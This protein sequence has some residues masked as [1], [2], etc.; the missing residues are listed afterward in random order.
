MNPLR[1]IAQWYISRSLDLD[2]PVPR[3]VARRM[4]S[5]PQ[6]RAFYQASLQ[7]TRQ[8]Q[9]K[10]TVDV[11]ERPF[12]VTNHGTSP[13]PVWTWA[14]LGTMAAAVTILVVFLSRPQNSRPTQ[15]QTAGQA[16]RNGSHTPSREEALLLV[17]FSEACM[18]QSLR[19]FHSLSQ[20]STRPTWSM[21]DS[22]PLKHQSSEL[23]TSVGKILARVEQQARTSPRKWMATGRDSVDYFAEEIPKSLTTWLG[24]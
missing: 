12:V 4:E 8:L 20:H 2:I 14:A 18:E 16:E 13:R 17:H 10:S 3:W 24:L 15:A 6:L 22:N 23:G 1:L 11:V 19:P 21:T 5:D 9:G 7:L